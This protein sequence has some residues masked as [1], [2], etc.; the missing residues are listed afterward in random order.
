LGR[1]HPDTYQGGQNY[2]QKLKKSEEVLCF[3][4]L[5]ISFRGLK[6]SPVAWMPFMGA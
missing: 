4:V 1:L 2:P 6:A 5:D 3:K